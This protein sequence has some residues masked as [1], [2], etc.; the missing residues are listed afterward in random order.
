MEANKM[1]II[2]L[3][4]RILDKVL[5]LEDTYEKE[6]FESENKGRNKE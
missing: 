4:F 6:L 3:I 2:E 5:G 1:N